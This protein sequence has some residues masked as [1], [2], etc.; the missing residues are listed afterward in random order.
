M[1]TQLI[2]RLGA[3]CLNAAASPIAHD[4]P[5]NLLGDHDAHAWTQEAGVRQPVND[6][7]PG[8]DA[9][10]SSHRT[11]KVVAPDHAVCPREHWGA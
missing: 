9:P 4:S 10:A 1:I 3:H 8:N 7:V 2:K 6:S 11:P 5:A